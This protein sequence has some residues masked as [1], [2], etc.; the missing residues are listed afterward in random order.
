MAIEAA[1]HRLRLKM[2][3][4]SDPSRMNALVRAHH[5]GVQVRI[6]LNADDHER[7]HFAAAARR[8]ST[9]GPTLTAPR[10]PSGRT[11]AR[12]RL[13]RWYGRRRSGAG[14]APPR[15]PAIRA[16]PPRADR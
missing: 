6:I 12:S 8:A 9:E 16:P 3:E 7:P 13:H 4:L 15:R 2:F 14:D 5:R 10:Y 1:T 11:A